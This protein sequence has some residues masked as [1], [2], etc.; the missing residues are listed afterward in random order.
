MQDKS[1]KIIIFTLFLVQFLDVLDFMV[2]MPLG[3]DFALSLNIPEADL[4]WFAA[5]YALSAAFTGI[6]SS[7]FIDRF[8]RKL[9]FIITLV[10]LILSNIFSAN[11]WN[12]E[13]LL[14]SRFLA[15][16]FGGPATSLCFAIVADIFD[17]KSR[18]AVMGKV[19]GG[20]SLAAVFGVP[21]GLKMSELFGWYASFYTVSIIGIFTLILIIIYLPKLDAHIGENKKNRI[22]YLSLFNNPINI[23]AFITTFIGSTAA[24]MIIPYITAFAQLNLDFPRHKIDY[25]FFIGG[26][27]SFFAMRL[28]GKFV[29]KKSSSSMAIF[30]N[31]FIIF[32]LL[33]GFIIS[34]KYLPVLLVFPMFMVGMAIRNVSNY[35][36]FSKIPQAKERAG[37]MSVISCV[38]HLASSAGSILASIILVN[39]V[40]S[41]IINMEIVVIISIILFLITPFMLK[42]I[43]KDSNIHLD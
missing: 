27:L 16:A 30:S 19:M 43:E 2:V 41:K 29:D 23:M 18:G 28:T 7:R 6:L 34:I 14:A 3:P 37:F 36:L 4:G 35:T 17:K 25:I 10:G 40:G 5:S 38:Q 1:S 15:G 31:I 13:S 33:F 24:F 39:Q 11:A 22:T 12:F 21:I 20:F 9:V 32:S 26:A 42:Y 8:E